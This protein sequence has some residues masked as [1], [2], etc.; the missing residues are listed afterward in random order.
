LRLKESLFVNT[1]LFFGVERKTKTGKAESGY[2]LKVACIVLFRQKV[3][4][5]KLP[6]AFYSDM[7]KQWQFGFI[8]RSFCWD[9]YLLDFI[10]VLILRWRRLSYIRKIRSTK[11]YLLCPLLCRCVCRLPAVSQQV[12]C[13]ADSGHWPARQHCKRW[14]ASNQHSFLLSD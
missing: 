8:P 13:H 6:M 10:R 14:R 5:W 11:N 1:R 2:N 7:R 3:T 9:Q 4:I 12:Y